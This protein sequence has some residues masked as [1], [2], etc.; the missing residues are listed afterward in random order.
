VD[1]SKLDAIKDIATYR[2]LNTFGTMAAGGM[3]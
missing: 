1:F 3:V 2:G